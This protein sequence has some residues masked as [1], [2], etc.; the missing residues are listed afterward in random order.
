M[1]KTTNV[2]IKKSR[3]KRAI[4]RSLIITILLI[5]AAII[6]AN[7]TSYFNINTI[8]YKGD[9]LITGDYVKEAMEEVKGE[10]IFSLNKID[11]IKKIKENP[12]I[13]EVQISKK[14]PSTIEVNINE[15]KGIYYEKSGEVY[16]IISSDLHIL[17]KTNSI[18]G[19]KLI[20]LKGLDVANTEVGQSIGDSERSQKVLDLFYKMEEKMQS[21]QKG[22]SITSLDISDLSN[23]KAYFGDVEVK[24]GN[25]EN[26][27][28][29]MSDA[30]N[31]YIQAKPQKYINVNFNGSPDFQ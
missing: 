20:E 17:E 10:K 22:V 9:S 5:V 26:L 15:K 24:I 6:M 31:I 12:Y 11:I 2:Y 28:K 4:K 29:K 3:R 18:E 16:N 25:D 13:D 19:K 8:L 21:E 7:K 30:M 27:T 1:A 23:I 14:I